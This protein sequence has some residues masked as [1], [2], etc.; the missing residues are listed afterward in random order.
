MPKLGSS[1]P[2][3]EEVWFGGNGISEYDF[4]FPQICVLILV[5]GKP[6]EFSEV[7]E[8]GDEESS[9]LGFPTAMWMVNHWR[10]SHFLFADKTLIFCSAMTSF[11]F[12]RCVLLSYIGAE[13]EFK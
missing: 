3:A 6:S 4:A 10:F 5:N 2:N 8:E 7:H 11:L 13:D 9:S 1:F 12:L